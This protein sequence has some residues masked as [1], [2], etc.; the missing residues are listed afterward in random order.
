MKTDVELPVRV[1]NRIQHVLDNFDLHY[2][3]AHLMANDTI[4]I[5]YYNLL[6]NGNKSHGFTRL[7]NINVDFLSN[8]YKRVV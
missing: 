1:I 4:E 5:L 2:Q 7:D 6:E 3:S 8:Y